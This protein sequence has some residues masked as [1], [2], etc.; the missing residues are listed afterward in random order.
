MILPSLTEIQA[1]AELVHGVIPPTPQIRWPLL[2]ARTGAEIWVKHENHSPVGAFK[3][4]G[5]LVYMDAL[6]RC[7]PN[8]AG[9]IAATRG[10][11]GQSVAFAASRAGLRAIIV[12]PFGNSP[13]KNSAM[14]ALGAELVEYGSDFQEA[15]EHSA[16][17]AEAG[18]LH[19][20]RSF[21]RTLVAGVATYALELFGAVADLDAVYVPIGMGSGICG[22]IAVRNA[23]GLRTEVVGVVA[24]RAPAYARSFA[25]GKPIAAETGETIADG[26]ACRLPAAEAL[27]AM[28]RDVS[29]IVTVDE[30]EIRAAMRHLFSDTHNVAEG[31]GAAALAA[32][33]QERDRMRGRR[34]A[35]VLSGGN[36]DTGVF[37]ATL[38]GEGRKA[39]V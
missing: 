7:E 28:L 17:L 35:A 33:L 6:R 37:A 11:H 21:D 20:V 32:L 26:M 14:R 13:E 4:R 30:E 19:L 25:A 12:V 29:R 9:V 38:A 10:N 23:L 1:A 27:E 22:V 8:V 3:L 24:T 31:A 16:K 5:G 36:V 2:C 39:A 34:V 18:K 15:Y